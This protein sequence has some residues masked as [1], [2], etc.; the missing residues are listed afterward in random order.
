[1]DVSHLEKKGIKSEF[2]TPVVVVGG[3]ADTPDAVVMSGIATN[4]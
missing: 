1:M 2:L 4:I 3:S